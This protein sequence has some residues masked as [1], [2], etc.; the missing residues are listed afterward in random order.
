[1]FALIF[2][3]LL[4]CALAWVLFYIFRG[5]PEPPRKGGGGWGKGRGPKAPGP[6]PLPDR[7]RPPDFIPEWVFEQVRPI[8]VKARHPLSRPPKPS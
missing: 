8:I 3:I 7:W 2:G 1:M 4:L 6:K 5:K